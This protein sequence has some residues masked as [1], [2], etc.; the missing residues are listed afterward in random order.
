MITVHRPQIK[1]KS[2]LHVEALVVRQG[3]QKAA[4]LGINNITIEGDNLAT[5]NAL[6]ERWKASWEILTIITDIQ[7]LLKEFTNVHIFHCFR[8]EKKAAGF[9]ACMNYYP[10]IIMPDPRFRMF[11]VIVLKDEK[12]K[13]NI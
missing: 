9:L 1:A 12:I 4:E 6:R 7:T 13:P 11:N 10:T 3:I 8:E 2:A 5:I